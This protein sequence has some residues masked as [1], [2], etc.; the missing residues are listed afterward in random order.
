LH[1][2]DPRRTRER[3]GGA[4]NLF[5]EIRAGEGNGNPDPGGMENPQQNQL[6]EVHTKTHS[7]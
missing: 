4:E 6:N 1:Y 2:R 5:E 3:K 7:N